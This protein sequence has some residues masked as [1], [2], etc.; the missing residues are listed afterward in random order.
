MTKIMQNRKNARAGGGFT[1]LELIAVMGIIV[2]MSLVIVG[3]YSGIMRAISA[4]AGINSMRKIATLCRQHA[5]IDGARTYFQITGVNTYVLFRKAGTISETSTSNRSGVDL[6]PYISSGS[7]SGVW[8]Y[9]LYADLGSA[10]ESFDTSAKNSTTTDLA[11]V[12]ATNG[13]DGALI[14][15]MENGAMAKIKY[16]PWYDSRDDKWIMGLDS[17][18]ASDFG[19]SGNNEADD[20]PYGW[21]LYPD[22]QLPKGYVFDSTMYKLDSDGDFVSGN[23]FYFEPDGRADSDAGGLTITVK[24][25]GTD[26]ASSLEISADG[27]IK[28]IY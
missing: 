2:A 9:D 24:E 23:N 1:L 3:S 25:L 12:M 15:N 4:T 10:A 6:P 18:H 27:K 19:S 7:C 11:K 13:Y 14:I 16:P 21:A 20:Y 5:C 8:L 17:K 28:A 26:K 22:Q